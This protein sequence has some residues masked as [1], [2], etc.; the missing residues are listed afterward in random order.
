MNPRETRRD[1]YESQQ[2]A[3][4]ERIDDIQVLGFWTDLDLVCTGT[5]IRPV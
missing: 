4:E 3:V 1:D 2:P 5:Y